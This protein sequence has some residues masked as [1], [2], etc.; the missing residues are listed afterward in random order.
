VPHVV[1]LGDQTIE[2]T[3]VGPSHGAGMIVMRVPKERVLNV[4]D[5]CT[6]QRIVF[7]NFPDTSPQDL[8]RLSIL[9]ALLFSLDRGLPP[10][11]LI[12]L[13]SAF[14][15]GD[16]QN[17]GSPTVN[18]RCFFA[19]FLDFHRTNFF[20]ILPD[21]SRLRGRNGEFGGAWKKAFASRAIMLGSGQDGVEYSRAS[22]EDHASQVRTIGADVRPDWGPHVNKRP[23]L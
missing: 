9:L 11:P 8:A 16:A 21:L 12:A 4:V 15:S 18:F 22:A 23:Q 13:S 17:V 3:Y 19:I 6:P 20:Q 7:R 14:F 5:I 10:T 1:T 2:L